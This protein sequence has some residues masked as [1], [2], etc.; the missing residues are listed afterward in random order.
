MYHYKVAIAVLAGIYGYINIFC[1]WLLL[2]DRSGPCSGGGVINS[3]RAYHTIRELE[4][5]SEDGRSGGFDQSEQMVQYIDQM[6]DSPVKVVIS[7]KCYHYYTHQT[8][9]KS[10]KNKRNTWYHE[11]DMGG[12]FNVTNF[13]EFTGRDTKRLA[14]IELRKMGGGSL[15]VEYQSFEDNVL[16]PESQEYLKKW[17]S[18]LMESNK[19]RDK[20]ISV[21]TSIWNV[22][23]SIGSR[24]VKYGENDKS[25]FISSRKFLIYHFFHVTFLYLRQYLKRTRLCKLYFGKVLELKCPQF[26]PQEEIGEQQGVFS[27]DGEPNFSAPP[28]PV[29]YSISDSVDNKS[30]YYSY[31]NVISSETHQ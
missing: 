27:S 18:I 22:H 28:L 24:L 31:S 8:K 17:E 2:S 4:K 23:P 5:I 16:E 10:I 11:Y 15:F 9:K 19:H 12:A 3:S 25:T 30:S 26:S 13:T 21:T 6:I 7:V 29:A 20:Y 14:E 1:R